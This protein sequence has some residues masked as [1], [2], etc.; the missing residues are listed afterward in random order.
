METASH[1]LVAGVLSAAATARVDEVIARLRKGELD[2]VDTIYVVD[3]E[4]KL[5]GGIPLLDLL[6]A[7]DEQTVGELADL[8]TPRDVSAPTELPL[9]DGKP[10]HVW[11]YN[12]QVLRVQLGD[13]VRVHFTRCWC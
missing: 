2:N 11:A 9:V 13:T 4:G 6:R 1:H 12:G 3:T 5:I 7:P 8:A 10:L